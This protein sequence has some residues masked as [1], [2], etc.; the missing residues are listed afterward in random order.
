MK[1]RQHFWSWKGS[2]VQGSLRIYHRDPRLNERIQVSRCSASAQ[3]A[4]DGFV[5]CLPFRRS[6]E[7]LQRVNGVMGIFGG[8]ELCGLRKTLAIASLPL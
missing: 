5:V 4:H 8:S 6:I 2:Q 1:P 3:P 7:D